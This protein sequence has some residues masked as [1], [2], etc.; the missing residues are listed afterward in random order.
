[1]LGDVKYKTYIIYFFEFLFCISFIKLITF[2]SYDQ[3]TYTYYALVFCFYIL[4][5]N[6]NNRIK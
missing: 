5:N 2:N 1:M 4:L 6:L 3:N